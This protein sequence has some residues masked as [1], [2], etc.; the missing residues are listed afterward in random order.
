MTETRNYQKAKVAQKA[1]FLG[2]QKL[3]LTTS[4]IRYFA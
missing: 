1:S 3:G 4:Y 2:V